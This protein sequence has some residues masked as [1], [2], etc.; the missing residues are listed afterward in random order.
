MTTM[1]C[2]DTFPSPVI[3][4][5]SVLAMMALALGMTAL[6]AQAAVVYGTGFETSDGGTSG[7]TTYSTYPEYITTGGS[8]V[9]SG[10]C[11][12]GIAGPSDAYTRWESP[13]FS[14]TAGETY[15]LSAWVKIAELESRVVDGEVALGCNTGSNII[16][17]YVTNAISQDWAQYSVSW[18][19][20]ASFSSVTVALGYVQPSYA[21]C[22]REAYFDDVLVTVPEPAAAG[23]LALGGLVLLRRKK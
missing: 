10:T 13:S 17:A 1:Q 18:T 5:W 2:P 19:P 6:P 4:L 7:W 16:W 20:S 3:H 11:S 8:T 23:L 14:V 9:H 22:P 21:Y 15:T 12:V